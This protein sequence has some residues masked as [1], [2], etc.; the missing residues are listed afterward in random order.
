LRST[1]RLDPCKGYFRRALEMSDRRG[2]LS[3][4]LRTATSLAIAETSD[5][6]REE[7]RV[8]LRAALAK[9][10]DGSDTFDLRLAKR[11]LDGSYRRDDMEDQNPTVIRLAILTP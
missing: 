4:T 2:S 3:W 8:I 11:V 1:E 10:R 5:A 7:A 9:F 6:G